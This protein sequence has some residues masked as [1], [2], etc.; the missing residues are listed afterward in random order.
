[1]LGVTL[2][3]VIAVGCV[4]AGFS[5]RMRRRRRKLEEGRAALLVPSSEADAAY[6][7]AE[8][9][10]HDLPARQLARPVAAAP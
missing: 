6:V 10:A 4:L 1:M 5:C 9:L 7:P 3:S 8:D 2:G